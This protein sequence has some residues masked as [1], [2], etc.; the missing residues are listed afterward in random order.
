[1]MRE[2]SG[3]LAPETELNKMKMAKKSGTFMGS[4]FGGS[5]S[6][7]S[8]IASGPGVPIG[9][10]KMT[11]EMIL[12]MQSIM[13]ETMLK[14]IQLQSDIKTLGSEIDKLS[15]ENSGLKAGAQ[16]SFSSIINTIANN[17]NEK[18]NHS[19]QNSGMTKK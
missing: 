5:S 1:M 3:R 17:A 19:M 10:E 13:E 4:L 9:N 12:Q 2:K 11:S 15:K 16:T 7:T 18:N 8:S 6:S 14:N